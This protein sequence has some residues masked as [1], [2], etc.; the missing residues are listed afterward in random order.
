M[1]K[2]Y[3]GR[4]PGFDLRAFLAKPEGV[5]SIAAAIGRVFDGVIPEHTIR[6]MQL[7]PKTP[8]TKGVD[9]ATIVSG[10][11]VIVIYFQKNVD[12]G[13]IDISAKVA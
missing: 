4:K 1:C 9:V 5:L 2:L 7:A 12:D 11:A 13:S 10:D 8:D 3:H 6:A